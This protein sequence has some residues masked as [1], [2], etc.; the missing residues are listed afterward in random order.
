MICIVQLVGDT[1]KLEAELESLTLPMHF[2]I[3]H[4]DDAVHMNEKPSDILRRKRIR[5]F[6]WPA[7]RSRMARRMP[8]SAPGTPALQWPAVC[9]LWG[10]CLGWSAL[11]LPPCCPRK[12]SRGRAGAGANVD[13]RPTTRSSLVLWV[14]RLP[15]TCWAM[16]LRA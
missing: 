5:P 9:S 6:R 8:L 12:K 10:V 16:P 4:A 7:V 2:D 14:M 1:P 3:V 13:C 11:L 15:A